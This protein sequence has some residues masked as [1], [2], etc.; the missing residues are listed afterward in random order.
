MRITHTQ[1]GS[2]DVISLDESY[3]KIKFDSIDDMKMF[4]YPDAFEK[5]LTFAD[6][7]KQIQALTDLHKKQLT[8]EEQNKLQA[9][10][11]LRQRE[12]ELAKKLEQIKLSKKR[13]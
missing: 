9:A 10:K 4:K 11:E 13:R 6:E 7:G 5:Y 8:Q 2:G 3:I 1:F 12:K